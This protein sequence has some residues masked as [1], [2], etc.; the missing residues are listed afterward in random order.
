MDS[1]KMIFFDIDGTLLDHKGAEKEGINKFY[2]ANRFNE[3]C[4]FD[5]FKEVWVKYSDKNFEKFLNKEYSFEQQRAMRIID[6]YNEF[7]KQIA[8]DE[9]LTKFKDYL[10]AYESSW[11]AYED[12]IPC[13]NMLS[14][15]KLGVIS[16]GDYKQQMEKLRK[17][18]IVEYFSDIVAAGDVGYAKPDSKIFEIACQ[19]NNVN[20]ENAIYV[21]DNIKTDIIPA[22]EIGMKGILIERDRERNV[23]ESI[24]RIFALTDIKNV[25]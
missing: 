2:F 10:D 1:L 11:K 3:I 14:G 23:E 8:Y 22:K 5:K 7:N 20:M 9:A 25:L 24:N 17:M 16:N 12:V 18:N 4:D 6:V 19:R 15:Y 21:G 13:L